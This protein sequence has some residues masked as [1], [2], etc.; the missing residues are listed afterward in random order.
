MSQ[1]IVAPYGSWKSPITT[2]VVVAKFTGLGDLRPVG[3]ALYWLAS[4]PLEG[5]RQVVVRRAAD[6]TTMDLTPPGF[7]VRTRVHEYGGGAWLIV[8]DAGAVPAGGSL[9]FANFDDQRLYVQ[10]PP[11]AAPRALT[12]EGP[13]RYADLVLDES[14]GRLICVREDHGGAGQPVNTLAAVD[15]ASGESRVLVS[16]SDF[17][18]SPRLSPAAGGQRLAWLSWNHPNMPWDGTELWVAE[19]DANGMPERAERVAGGEDESIFQPEWSPARPRSLPA[20]PETGAP[21]GELHF[22]S[23]RTGWWNL[24]R[25][26]DGKTQALWPREAEFGEPQWVFGMSKYA[27]LPDG[28]IAAAYAEAGQWKLALLGP[29]DG[30]VT[31]LPTRFTEIDDLA[32]GPGCLTFAGGSPT[33]MY[34]LVRLDLMS[35]ET[36]VLRRVRD[37]TLDPGYISQPERVEFPTTGELTAFGF[38]YPPRNRDYRGPDGARPPLLVMS[39]GGPTGSTSSTLRLGIQYWTS[40][41]IAVLDVDYGGSSGMGRAYR[42]RLNGQWGVVD[43]DDCVNGAKYLVARGDVDEDHLAITGGSAGGYTTLC[44]LTFH[45]TFKAGASHFGISDLETLA[46]DTHK[47]ESRYLDRLVGP[48]PERKDL[49]YDRSPIHFTHK[50]S[51][52]MIL[53][54]G[55]DDPVVP[56]A[57]A[58]TMFEAVWAKELAVAYVAFPGEQHGFRKAENARRALEAE[59]YFYSKIFGFE[60]GEAVEP[61]EI[62]N[63]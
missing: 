49:Y 56:P 52:P 16:G 17:Y 62:E 50:L 40:R 13:I 35:G 63:L 41:G 3:D 25:V 24:Y 43:T 20:S 21:G 1:P 22:V 45:D 38:Y 15:L 12:P 39:H 28:R 14:R 34:S 60:L 6:G 5:G 55:L 44:A 37:V 26:R 27:F 58:Q 36:E 61:V 29:A 47:F 46:K 53:F 11:E 8:E 19:L 31:P 2:E 42:Q 48:Y 33:E 18:S 57:Q 10:T 51:R 23:D 7:N 9:Y 30:K 32:A 4:R 59:L 54:Q